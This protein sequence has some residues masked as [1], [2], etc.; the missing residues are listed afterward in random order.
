M[1]NAADYGYTQRR[2]RTFIFGFRKDSDFYN[3]VSNIKEDEQEINN[4][5]NTNKKMEHYAYVMLL[6]CDYFCCGLVFFGFVS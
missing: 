4:L 6:F 1:I 3:Y 5:I 2:R